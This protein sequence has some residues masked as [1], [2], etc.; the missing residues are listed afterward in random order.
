[1][2]VWENNETG[3]AVNI[4]IEPDSYIK[5][6]GESTQPGDRI[7]EDTSIFDDHTLEWCIC[8]REERCDEVDALKNTKQYEAFVY[9]GRNW[10]VRPQDIGNI[11]S[12]KIFASDSLLDETAYPWEGVDRIW[13]DRE[14]NEHIFP[15]QQDYINFAMAVRTHVG[16]LLRVGKGHK[17][18]LRLLTDKT[19]IENYD[20]ITGW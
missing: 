2:I 8:Y 15:T 1:M 5:K 14:N 20:I 10:D 9:G 11:M 16:G 3:T 17:D 6:E 12:Q 13:W 19:D 4:R 7:P 18:A